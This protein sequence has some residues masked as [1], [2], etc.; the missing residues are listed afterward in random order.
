MKKYYLNYDLSK[1][2][3]ERNKD[4]IEIKGCYLNVAKIVMHDLFHKKEFKEAKVVFGGWKI[5]F[6]S[7]SKSVETYIKHCFILL[8]DEII[9]VTAFKT[10]NINTNNDDYIIFKTFTMEEYLDN[11]KLCNGDTSL[12]KIMLKFMNDKSLELFKENIVLLG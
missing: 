3:Y 1:E 2:I 12:N 11:L 4:M 8:N 5:E 7:T 9:D 6:N 10:K